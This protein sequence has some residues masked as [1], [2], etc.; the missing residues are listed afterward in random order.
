MLQPYFG[1]EA[2]LHVLVPKS[3]DFVKKNF[4]ILLLKETTLPCVCKCIQNFV[5]KN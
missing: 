2:M 5:V 3:R 1:F 4:Y